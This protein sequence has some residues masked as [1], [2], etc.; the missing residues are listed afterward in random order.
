MTTPFLGEIQMFG[1][2]FNP[3]DWAFCN[4][5]LLPI[6]QN[7]ALF[8]LLGTAYG[9]D[10]RVTFQLPN[11]AGRAATSQGQ[12]PGLSPRTRGETFGSAGVALGTAQVPPHNHIL[13]V[14][15]QNDPNKRSGSPAEGNA[16]TSPTASAFANGA[17]PNV[18]FS[19]MMVASSPGGS[20]PHEN[21]QPYL[22]V[23]FCIALAG[24]FPSFN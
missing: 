1:F 2:N 23:N 6:S 17:T 20:L 24:V 10:G 15:S 14:F 3:K 18:A 21:Q 22:G 9:G 12:G 11:F 19:P 13:Q 5:A 4:G 8:S 7:T 16:L